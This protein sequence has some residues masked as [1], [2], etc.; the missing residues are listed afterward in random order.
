MKA[1]V[2]TTFFLLSGFAF[3]GTD[4]YLNYRGWD[5]KIVDVADFAVEKMGVEDIRSLESE[6]V[7]SGKEGQVFL[8][9]INGA[10]K[11]IVHVD[12]VNHS[13]AVGT[14]LLCYLPGQE[15]QPEGFNSS[16]F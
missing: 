15:K 14:A 3:A 7:S 5:E 6:R 11:V 9:T 12:L 2:F 16:S 1:F 8:V 10:K 13:S 4:C